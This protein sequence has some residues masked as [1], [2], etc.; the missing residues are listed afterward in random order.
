MTQFEEELKKALAR[1]EPS[2]G[3][4]ERVLA[5]VRAEPESTAGR[6]SFRWLRA[7][8]L[9]AVAA[10]VLAVATGTVYKRHDRQVRGEEAKRRLLVALRIAGSKLQEAQD[11]L[12]EVE[13]AEARQ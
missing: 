2:S 10:A 9:A 6:Q 12:K 4:S 7:W 1:R 5:K 13:S 3:F 8:R 11:R